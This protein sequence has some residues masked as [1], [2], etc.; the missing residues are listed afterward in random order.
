LQEK[1]AL[2]VANAVIQEKL[3]SGM[4]SR[5]SICISGIAVWFKNNIL[6]YIIIL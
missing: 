4:T 3:T 2:L 6:F 5:S 1:A